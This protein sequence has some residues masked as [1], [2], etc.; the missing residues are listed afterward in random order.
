M[1]RRALLLMLIL[2]AVASPA[3]AAM[4]QGIAGASLQ[5]SVTAG[6]RPV[7]G[8][9]VTLT[10]D[11]TGNVWRAVTSQRGA[12]WFDNLPIVGRFSLDVRALGYQ[13][14]VVRDIVLRLGDR[15]VRNV[16]LDASALALDAVI[17]GAPAADRD[18]GAGGPAQDISGDAAR[19][20]PLLDRDF[21]HLFTLSSQSTGASPPS[22]GGQFARFNA[23]QVDGGS[24][25]DF[26]GVEVTPGASADARS[27]PLEAIQE[28]RILV[29]P[30]DVRDGGF[31]GGLINAVTRSGTN[32]THVSTLASLTA[33]GLV[34]NDPSGAAPQRFSSAEYGLTAAGPVI[35]NRLHYFASGE[36]KVEGAPAVST[37]A[38]ND[39]IAEQVARISRATYGFDPGGTETPTLRNPTWNLFTKLSWQASP[40]HLVDMSVNVLGGRLDSLERAIVNRTNRDGWALSNSGL[41]VRTSSLTAR[42]RVASDLGAAANELVASWAVTS[43]SQDSRLAVPLFLVQTDA[44][45]TYVAAGSFKSAEG[46]RT[47]ERAVEL[48]DNFSWTAGRHV[49]TVGTQDQLLHFDDNILVTS[50]GVWTFPSASS[51][52]LAQPSRYEVTFPRQG[53]LPSYSSVA[54]ASYAQDRW[55]PSSR[56]TVTVGLRYDVPTFD[57]PARDTALANDAALGHLDTSRFPSG[58]GE[59]A[60]RVGFSYDARGGERPWIV[61]GGVGSFVA[62]P[63]Y[64]WMTNAYTDVADLVCDA[65]AGVPAPTT[66]IGALP[67]SCMLSGANAVPTTT[68]FAPNVRF[69]ETVKADVGLEHSL[70]RAFTASVDLMTARTSNSFA[71]TDRNLAV[72]GVSTEE[73]IMYGTIP[74]IGLARPNRI[75]PAFGPVYRVD[76]LSGD[77]YWS[78][79][80]S[81]SRQWSDSRL[82]EIGYTWSR[83]RDPSSLFGASSLLNFQN[84]PIGTSL[85]DRPLSRSNRDVPNSLVATG[86]TP[87][88]FGATLSGI[89][90]ARSGSPYAYVANG[91]A[92]ADGAAGNDLFYVPRSPTDISLRDP[93][94][95]AALDSF[96]QSE[97]CLRSQRGQIMARN[98]CRNPSVWTLDARLAK[99]I[100][101]LELSADVFDLP[102][103]IDRRWGVTRAT[104]LKE[105][106]AIVS[107]AGWDPRALRPLYSLTLPVRDVAL[108]GSSEWRIQ[109]GVRQSF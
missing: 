72:T 15:A 5:G 92:N 61:R 51:Y 2:A 10:N 78:A 57:R 20:L 95:Y 101:G 40:R 38:V 30:F 28:I 4:A 12:F 69:P 36:V 74:P 48:T 37:V 108:P 16:A 80:W 67:R 104:A 89:L 88:G 65:A 63:P 25:G 6:P 11:S 45:S 91:D 14:T 96:I 24:A 70:G 9:D 39:S 68:T 35:R 94:Q 17:V 60:P 26:L 73:R 82:L 22:I 49:L 56:L 58:N 27:L 64:V 33:S 103:L 87:M 93:S 29:S 83:T 100:R 107:A 3:R 66:N 90:Q 76:N 23:I 46:T 50:W 97:S 32:D 79:T 42:A 21:V 13:H 31:S 8:A 81:V 34:G 77:R 55:S 1:R 98:S 44:P 102:N 54:V 53:G 86:V 59:L 47:N 52:A 18:P 105:G 43:N 75:D 19:R 109:V 71:V 62:R 7:A 99:S 85:N 106:V 41:A 84:N